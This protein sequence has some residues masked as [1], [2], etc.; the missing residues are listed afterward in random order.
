MGRVS[1]MCRG[2]LTFSAALPTGP[3]GAIVIRHDAPG[4]TI[5]IITQCRIAVSSLSP[6]HP[7]QHV[8]DWPT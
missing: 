7:F 5:R 6:V 8:F 4:K 3:R 1:R 2:I